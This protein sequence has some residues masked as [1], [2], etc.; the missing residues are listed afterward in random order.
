MADISTIY[1]LRHVAKKIGEDD[2]FVG[3][4]ANN[5]ELW[6]G[7]IDIHDNQFSDDNDWSLKTGFTDDGIDYLVELIADIRSY[8]A[9]I[10]S[11]PKA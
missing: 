9:N 2:E 1:T 11:A 5:M 6:D 8:E 4:I 7:C 3:E 10:K